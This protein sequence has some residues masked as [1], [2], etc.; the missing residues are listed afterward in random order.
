MVGFP[1][2]QF[3]ATI[4]S[5]ILIVPEKTAPDVSITPTG[6]RIP[7]GPIGPAEPDEPV[8]PRGPTI[9]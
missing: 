5:E 9:P 3:P 6:P 7:V 4:K 8:G 2:T 1:I